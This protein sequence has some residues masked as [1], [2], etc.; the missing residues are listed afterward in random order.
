MGG[1][2]ARW[3]SVGETALAA[4]LSLLALSLPLSLLWMRASRIVWFIPRGEMVQPALMAAVAL[5]STFLFCTLS[6]IVF[7]FAWTLKRSDTST[8]QGGATVIYLGEAAG[9]ALGG[10]VF[11]FFFLTHMSA[12]A[13]TLIVSGMIGAAA[14]WLFQVNC[15]NSR[16]RGFSMAIMTGAG[17]GLLAALLFEGGLDHMTRQW[18]WGSEVVAVQDTPFHN[19]ALLRRA[20]QFSLFANGQWIFSAPDP[21]TAEFSIRQPTLHP[22]SRFSAKFDLR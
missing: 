16:R 9:G 8:R 11:Y 5:S 2:L 4:S 17:A 19:L 7:A 21:Q 12:L 13:T 14:S 18:Q 15:S 20:E 1:I 3:I 10:F 22:P 6:G